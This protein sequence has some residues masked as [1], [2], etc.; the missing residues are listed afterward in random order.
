MTFKRKNVGFN[1]KVGEEDV[2]REDRGLRKLL[3]VIVP[4]LS[5]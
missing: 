5:K 3:R 2:E 1:K 4:T